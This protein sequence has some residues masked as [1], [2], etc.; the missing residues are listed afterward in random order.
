M[1]GIV[2]PAGSP[3]VQFEVIGAAKDADEYQLG[4]AEKACPFIVWVNR[5]PVRGEMNCGCKV[6][7]SV[8]DPTIPAGLDVNRGSVFACLCMGRFVE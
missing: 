3:L 8:A 1:S 5:N 2:V 6:R 7:F 4:R